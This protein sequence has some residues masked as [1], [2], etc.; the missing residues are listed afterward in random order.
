[1]PKKAPE[2]S[3]LQVKRLSQ[4][5]VYTV[6]GVAGLMLQ[7]V[8]SGSKS[9]L[10][11]YRFGNKRPE[12]GLGSY[13]DV[14]LAD[15][16]ESAR[17]IRKKIAE[18]IDVAEERRQ[19]RIEIHKQQQSKTS[20]EEV[21]RACF[22]VKVQ[23]FKNAKH[24]EQW[25]S[26]LENYV[27][28]VIGSMPVTEV[29]THDVLGALKPIWS[30]IP[31]TAGRIR[32]RIAATFDYARSAGLRSGDNPAAWKGCLE[33]L[34][35][36]VETMKRKKGSGNQPAVVIAEASL[37]YLDLLARQ[38]VSALALRFVMLTACRSGEARLAEW[39][40][41]D[42]SQRVWIVPAD[43]MKAGKEHVIPLTD[44]AV[45]LLKMLPRE[46]G[47]DFLFPG[48]KKKPLSDMTLSKMLKDLSAKTGRYIDPVSG[49]IAVPH[50]LRSTFKDWARRYTA[51][52]DEVSELQ[53]AHVSSDATRAAYARDALLDKRRQLMQDWERFCLSGFSTATVTP[54][55]NQAATS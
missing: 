44:E 1:M 33:P 19:Q 5:G 13:P 42:L 36:K 23:E 41:V 43:R 54:I 15:A 29:G 47:C 30:E 22:A 3:A 21:A 35:P 6:G 31:E 37:L 18:G 32:Q 20:F 26:S 24:A 53:L 7:V 25:L 27:F 50:G 28:P 49:R 52:A 9:W 51:Y 14:G 48:M 46:P 55:R 17:A 11:R 16:R 45:E 12:L 38:S 8:E 39:S 4:P 40:E 2:M 34:L 10:L